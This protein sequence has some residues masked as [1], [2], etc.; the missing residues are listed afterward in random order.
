MR[1]AL[2]PSL[3]PQL[4]RVDL[5]VANVVDVADVAFY[6]MPGAI[7]CPILPRGTYVWGKACS[8]L[9][10]QWTHK[11]ECK[12]LDKYFSYIWKWLLAGKSTL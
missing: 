8:Y 3:L 4:S 1:P 5:H 6:F 12:C 10:L 9:S 2:R 11:C 7:L